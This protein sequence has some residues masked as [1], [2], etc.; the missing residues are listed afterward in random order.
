MLFEFLVVLACGDEWY[1]WE[2]LISTI[3][4]SRSMASISKRVDYFCGVSSREC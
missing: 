1:E 3:A 2:E 4:A